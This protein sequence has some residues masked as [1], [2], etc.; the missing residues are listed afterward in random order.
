MH[1]RF[2]LRMNMSALF[3]PHHTHTLPPLPVHCSCSSTDAVLLRLLT[4]CL[5]WLCMSAVLVSSTCSTQHTK[6]IDCAGNT[7][8]NTVV[9][10]W[11]IPTSVCVVFSLNPNCTSTALTD[12][13]RCPE[14]SSK[15]GLI[16]SAVI[17]SVDLVSFRVH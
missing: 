17:V 8:S 16:S 11:C 2:S 6:C 13:E 14:K 3:H 1:D 10:G 4:V 15:S 7:A 12:N 5:C 9:C